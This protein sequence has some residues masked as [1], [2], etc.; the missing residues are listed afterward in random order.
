MCDQKKYRVDTFCCA[1]R[2][3]ILGAIWVCDIVN[4]PCHIEKCPPFVHYEWLLHIFKIYSLLMLVKH[5]SGLIFTFETY[6]RTGW[7]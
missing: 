6:I 7:N 3:L 1:V 2:Q 5:P 4:I